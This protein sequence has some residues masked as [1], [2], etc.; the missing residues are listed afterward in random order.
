MKPEFLADLVDKFF[1][2]AIA[3]FAARLRAL[4]ARPAPERGERGEAGAAPSVEKL[5]AL[6][7]LAMQP[8]V[9]VVTA[10]AKRIPERGERGEP[11]PTG[12]DGR[13]GADGVGFD[14]LSVAYDGERTITLRF[15]RGARVSEFPLVLPFPIHRDVWEPGKGYA[16]GD[17]VTWGGSIF[18][19]TQDAPREKPEDGSGWRLIVKRGRDGRDGAKGDKGDT[20]SSGRAGRDLTNLGPDGSKWA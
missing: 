20:G 10:A 14:D 15:I 6:I 8:T 18:M 4:E 5:R 7:A 16:K 1:D 13:D 9:D 12:R 3:P 17:C 2:A 19:A 11:G